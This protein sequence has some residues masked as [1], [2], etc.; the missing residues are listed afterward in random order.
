MPDVLLVYARNDESG[1]QQ[2]RHL[3]DDDSM[4]P[5]L[6][7]IE[8]I[9]SDESRRYLEAGVSAVIST[10][11]SAYQ[12]ISAIDQAAKGHS[13]STPYVLELF[14]GGEHQQVSLVNSDQ[15]KNMLKITDRDRKILKGLASGQSNSEIAR[16][17]SLATGTVSNRLG[18][19]YILLDVPDRSAAVYESMRLGLIT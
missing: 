19:L 14:A 1:L 6:A 4:P 15:H 11:A 12:I 5:L 8:D 13:E 7:I 17:L 3:I 10:R 18:E 2:V 9:H 16:D